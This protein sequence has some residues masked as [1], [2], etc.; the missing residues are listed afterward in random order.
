[1]A[2]LHSYVCG[3]FSTARGEEVALLD[4]ATEETV[5]TANC[6]GFDAEAA[7]QH[8]REVG[9]RALRALSFAQRGELLA[10]MAAA[11]HD[12]RDALIETS[13]RNGG[14]TRGGAK[15]DVDG[16]AGTLSAY[17][18]LG[19]RLGDARELGD[20][21]TV[22]IGRGA[23][24]AGRHAWVAREGVALFIN[25][26]NFPAWGFAEKAATALLAGMPIINKPAT[27]TAWTAVRLAEIL[28]EAAILPAGAFQQLLGPVKELLER[29]GPQD[30]VA[31]TGSSRTGVLVRS[32][33]ELLR[34]G[35]RV[36]VE[37]DSL[38][39]AV[40]GPD[41]DPDGA[42]WQT[43]LR[44]LVREISEKTGQKCTATRRV[45][46]P[47]ALLER[48]TAELADRLGGLKIGHPAHRDVE[49]GPLATR[50]QMEDVQ[51]GCARM[52]AA[53]QVA[54][55]R[56]RPD[57]L[58]DVPAG[59][60]FFAGPM[61]FVA[62]DERAVAAAHQDEIFGPVATVIPFDGGVEAAAA[63]VRRGGGMLVS[64]VYSDDRAWSAGAA[65]AMAPWVGRLCLVDSRSDG[66]TL[67]PGMVLPD[68][69]HGGPGRAGGGEELGGLRGVHHYMART[70]FQGPRALVERL[71]EA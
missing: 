35:V 11:I 1:M 13:V 61:L 34:H 43:L 22:M 64:T 53:A 32:V 48:L 9:G 40:V 23:K 51:R 24:L 70:A 29:L 12:H 28:I 25:A 60:G 38:N 7:L 26:F 55:G 8:A 15:F 37:A 17:A 65:R 67:P 68:L 62:R 5:A 45:I 14:T 6:G 44:D 2:T 36:N 59:K 31:F 71:L 18:E 54:F 46:V 49:V 52:R 57:A 63:L 3:A 10:R 30:V 58:I 39:A 21:E 66:A 20:G 56:E 47:Q 4:P 41:L 19:R 16:A 33:P 69:V 42:A 50:Q 27:A